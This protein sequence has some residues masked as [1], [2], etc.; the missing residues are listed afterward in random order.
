MVSLPEMRRLIRFSA[1]FSQRTMQS[2]PSL[3]LPSQFHYS[4]TVPQTRMDIRKRLSFNSNL[5]LTTKQHFV[6]EETLKVST[7]QRRLC[8]RCEGR[9][10]FRP[11]FAEFVGD[12]PV[13][14]SYESLQV[15]RLASVGSGSETVCQSA[16]AGGR[17]M[18]L[19]L[20]GYKYGGKV[21][22]QFG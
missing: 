3:Q 22:V 12:K 11:H 7:W 21:M 1:L 17:R 14:K 5:S 20:G 2:L 8:W 19:R 6:L 16:A 15:V 10:G 18:G 4:Q 13:W 9:V